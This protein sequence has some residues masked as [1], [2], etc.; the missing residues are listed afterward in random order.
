MNFN[1]YGRTAQLFDYQ[2]MSDGLVGG[3]LNSDGTITINAASSSWTITKYIPVVGREFTLQRQASGGATS[4]CLYDSNQTYITGLAYN[5]NGTVTVSANTDV[6][7]IRFT[8][9]RTENIGN[10]M[11]NEGSTPLPYEPYGYLWTD[12]PH[13]IHNTATDTLTTLPA[14][15]YPNDITA[16]VGLK[17]NMSQTGTPTP[18]TPIQPSEC[19]DLETTGEHAG[20]YK[21]PIL[22]AS[23]TTPVY[24]GE[25]ET[26][27][28]IQKLVL[29]GT[30]DWAISNTSQ[31][32]YVA[33]A[34]H[35]LSNDLICYCSHYKSIANVS[36]MTTI[37]DGECTFSNT[38]R[39]F[40]VK[41][42]NYNDATA[43]KSYLAQQYAAGTPVT[44]WYVL[45]TSTT[46]IVNEPLRKIGNYA[47][48]VS[49]ITIPVTAGGDTLS[50]GTTVQPS[51]VTVNYKGWHTG[52][53]H[54]RDGGQWQ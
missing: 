29:T 48:A 39:W 17:G 9:Y 33:M 18:T 11:L 54:E 19:G 26:T 51:E 38:L 12:T 42:D 7:Y 37:A 32:L 27:R 13:Y 41:D 20:Q 2:T 52:A 6:S 16:T 30:E 43:F 34:D 53:V 47:D 25:V 45:A 49:G 36:S 21:I 24:L 40:Y 31:V 1:K 46:G 50:V 4:I 15:L 28:K 44:V 23:T 10:I 35:L 22:S 5:G 3:V 14:V 8:Y